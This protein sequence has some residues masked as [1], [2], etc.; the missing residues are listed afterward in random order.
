MQKTKSQLTSNQYYGGLNRRF[1]ARQRRL[2]KMGFLYVCN[3]IK[4][5]PANFIKYRKWSANARV[6]SAQTV[7]VAENR[8]YFDMLARITR[9]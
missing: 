2:R 3:E 4:G 1:E 8:V 9:G 6:I 7:L 5:A